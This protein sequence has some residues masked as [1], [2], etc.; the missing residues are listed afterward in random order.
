MTEHQS[1]ERE[2]VSLYRQVAGLL[3]G[4]LEQGAWKVGDRLPALEALM[5]EYGVSRITLRQAIAMLEQEGLLKRGQGRGTFV[6]GDASSKRW[7]MVPT[8][9]NAL[10]THI[11]GL[12]G[13][14]VTLGDGPLEPQLRPGEGTPAAAYWH[15]HRVNYAEG[16]PYSLASIFLAESIRRK[17][18]AAYRTQVILPLLARHLGK[19]L[20]RATQALEVGTADIETARRLNVAVG[21]PIAKVRRVVTDIQQRVVYCAELAYPASRLRLETN[22]YP[23]LHKDQEHSA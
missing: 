7:L 2:G 11:K 5:A 9:W 8:E 20:G 3:R 15:T 16:V 13:H 17:A 18:P 4:K 19:Q 21:T 14:F 10:I 23:P 1:L 22:L 12:S 6:T